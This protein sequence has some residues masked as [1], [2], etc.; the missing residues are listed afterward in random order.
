MMRI[1]AG[2]HRG[3]RL[4][5]VTAQG[6]RPTSDRVREAVFNIIARRIFGVR[7]LDLFAGTGALG[8]EALSRGAAHTTFLDYATQACDII[9]KNV[10]RCGIHENCDIICHDISRSPLPESIKGPPFSLIFMDPPYGTPLLENTLTSGFLNG[11]L[12]KDGMIIAEHSV[13]SPLPH[14]ITGLDIHDQRKY[15]KTLVSFLTPLPSSM[16][17]SRDC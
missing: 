5:A 12:S 13:K 9:K 11:L 16:E 7:V 3:R 15:G 14:S 4:E 1:I 10:E 8:I 17:G 6:I 2:R